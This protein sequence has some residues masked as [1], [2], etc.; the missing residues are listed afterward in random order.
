MSPSNTPPSSPPMSPRVIVPP[1]T[2]TKAP[3]GTTPSIRIPAELHDAKADLDPTE[4]K[5]ILPRRHDSSTS[6]A[7]SEAWQYLSQFHGSSGEVMLPSRRPSAGYRSSTSLSTMMS[8]G[9]VPSL[10]HTPS[11]V[12]SS[13]NSNSDYV[14]YMH[15]YATRP[16]PPRHNPSFST[17]SGVTKGLELVMPHISAPAADDVT[18]TIADSESVFPARGSV[19]GKSDVKTYAQPMPSMT[20]AFRDVEKSTR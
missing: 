9:G 11:T 8:G 5:P 16:L 14:S 1:M 13:F 6:L 2:P 17:S 10:T 7:S 18:I 3:A 4:W 12:A 20:S 19:W 15:E